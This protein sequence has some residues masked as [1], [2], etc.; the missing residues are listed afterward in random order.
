MAV[1]AASRSE[2]VSA[3]RCL[4]TL[5][6]TVLA[7]GPGLE[8]EVSL[9]SGQAV[10]D[11]L[12]RL[13]HRVEILD[14]NP[15]EMSALTR[16]CDIV[17]IALH[18]EFGEDG[19]LQSELER[20]K[21]RFTGS[22]SAA[23]RLAM[24]KPAAKARVESNGVPTPKYLVLD[25][26]NVTTVADRF[27]TPAVVKPVSSGS[28]VDTFIVRSKDQLA[29]KTRSLV[30]QYGSALVEAYIKGPELTVGVLGDQVLPVCQIRTSREF[31][32]YHAKYIADDT[33]YLFDL[34]L[35]ASLLRRVQEL[36]LKAHRSLGCSVFSRVDWMVDEATIEPYFLE[37]NTIP[38]FTSHSLLPKAAARVG[39]SFD[40]LCQRIIELS[41]DRNHGGA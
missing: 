2:S 20:R 21:I 25:A 33:E 17:F 37:V 34:D 7:G 12:R 29:E 3:R 4:D 10:G 9:N 14:I 31:Y 22:G 6:I 13:G 38:G 15:A 41:W 32:D 8:R 39:I 40:A 5:D 23:S 26:S 30:S 24:S 27:P 35:P 1:A 18:G 19:A 36:S 16:P 11:A 28:S